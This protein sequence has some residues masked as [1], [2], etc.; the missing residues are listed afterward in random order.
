MEKKG[1]YDSRLG[2]EF[3]FGGSTSIV[4]LEPIPSQQHGHPR[5][6][7]AVRNL[8]RASV[9]TGGQVYL[10][11][12]GARLPSTGTVFLKLLKAFYPTGENKPC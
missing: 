3:N 8:P 7:Q 11:A 4:S 10:R 5:R 1:T 2:F 12:W 6:I 9:S